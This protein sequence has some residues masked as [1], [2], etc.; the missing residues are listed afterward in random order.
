MSG[1][2][3]GDGPVSVSCLCHLS[4][5]PPLNQGWGALVALKLSQGLWLRTNRGHC[6]SCAL[7]PRCLSGDHTTDKTSQLKQQGDTEQ[8]SSDFSWHL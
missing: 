7:T 8:V 5:P 2:G 6:G 4:L 3:S 1:V